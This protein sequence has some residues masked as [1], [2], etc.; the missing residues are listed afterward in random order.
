[1]TI[2]Q[3][4]NKNSQIIKI[5]TPKSILAKK[6]GIRLIYYKKFKFKK[7]EEKT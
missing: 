4:P 7:T 1:M 6:K 2:S 5:K 3:K